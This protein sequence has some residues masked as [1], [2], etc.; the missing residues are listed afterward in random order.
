MNEINSMMSR[1]WKN[2]KRPR[3]IHTLEEG[4]TYGKYVIEPLERGYGYTIGE[5]LER[6]LTS[7]I[8]GTSVTSFHIDGVGAEGVI[9]GVEQDLDFVSL[10][11]KMLQVWAPL[12][13]S[14]VIELTLSKG[15]VYA[16]DLDLSDDVQIFSPDLHICTVTAK[17]V[18]L[19]I[20]L[21]NGYGYA[22]SEEHEGVAKGFLPLDAHFSP[23]TRVQYHVTNARIGQRTDY[24]KLTLQVWTSGAVSPQEAI[25]Y[26]AQMF[27]AQMETFINFE[28]HDEEIIEREEVVEERPAYYSLLDTQI[29]ELNLPAR[30]EN[31]LRT[32]KIQYVGELVQRT[33]R[34]MTDIKNF[35]KKSLTD[36]QAALAKHDLKLGMNIEDWEPPTPTE[37]SH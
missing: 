31:C 2:L 37:I 25:I 15:E 33:D 21:R 19:K 23:V 24:N 32:A 29:S 16:R 11:L 10:Q 26:S 22:S 7:S 3:G 1:N 28:E 36:I 14:R 18:K 12:E 9:S 13:G 17:S 20:E 4:T 34:S 6:L 35:G 8:M 30:A 27:R 5:S